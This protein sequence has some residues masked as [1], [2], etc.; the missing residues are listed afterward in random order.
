[1]KEQVC[2]QIQALRPEMERLSADIHRTPEIGF[3]EMQAS[4]WLTGF[5]E[6]GGL[7]V[8][9]GIAGLPTA[10][11]ADHRGG[12]GPTIA[13]LAEYDA[14]PGLGHGCGHNLIGTA[15]C[16]AAIALATCWPDAPGTV[17]VIGTPAE[18]GG[19]GKILMLEQGVFDDVDV[20]MMFHP[21]YL[22]QI[23]YPSLAAT[24]IRLRYRG[25]PAHSAVHPHLGINAADAAM[26]FFAGVNALRQHVR[27]DVRLHGI[28]TDAGDKANIVPEHASVEFMVRADRREDVEALTERVRDVA[29]GAALMTG[30]D[31]DLEQGMTYFDARHCPTLGGLA[32]INFER[33]GIA[34]DPI[35]E[36]TPKASSD[37][38][39]VSHVIPHLAI[40]LAIADHPIAGHSVEWREAAASEYGAG[41]MVTAAEILALTAH[42]LLEDP[43]S[44]ETVKR[45]HA[46]ATAAAAACATS[47]ARSS[48]AM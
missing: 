10:F 26:L 6:R 7:D 36:E 16:A 8:R 20:V 9:R 47:T 42:D 27:P 25:R 29:R 11:R 14:L 38:G 28:I 3:E 12:D 2:R 37:G 45:E 23:D 15:S 33:L 21:S 35:D 18:E 41:A 40:S 44:L 19:G 22:N 17:S 48:R 32:R 13:F 4:G 34:E 46:Q 31:L 5:L 43:E 24:T 30:A 39:N 1:V